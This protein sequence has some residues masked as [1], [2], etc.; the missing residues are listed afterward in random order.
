MDSAMYLLAK[1]FF[2]LK[3]SFESGVHGRTGSRACYFQSN[4]VLQLRYLVMDRKLN[5][6]FF[7]ADDYFTAN[8]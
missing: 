8:G 2:P 4:V 3:I 6:G 1:F 5:K 7:L